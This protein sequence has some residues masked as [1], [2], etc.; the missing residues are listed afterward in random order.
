MAPLDA[1]KT[2]LVYRV[3]Y[4]ETDQMGMVYY[5]NYLIYFERARN[6]VLREL[7]FTYRA[8]EEMGLILPVIEAHCNYK[9]PARYDDL[10]DLYGHFELLS[11]TRMT[12][13]C[14]VWRENRLL[15]EGYTVHVCLDAQSHRPKK[16]PEAITS[17]LNRPNHSASP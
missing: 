11:A 14:E 3:P 13:W 17:K 6:E 9:Q 15:A 5:A 8:M 12:A 7:Q 10:L 1:R 4:A 16:L 2:H